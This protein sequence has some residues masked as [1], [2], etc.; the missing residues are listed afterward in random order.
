MKL[1]LW[2]LLD[3]LADMRPTGDIKD[4]APTIEAF[5][6]FAKG[7]PRSDAYVY[8]GS[9]AD[10]FGAEADSV[11]LVHRD[12]T[13]VIEHRAV[14]EV[15][16]RV[17]ETFDTYRLWDQRLQEARHAPQPY[18]AVLDV[19]HQMFHC[20]MFF[21]NKNL[22][23]YAITQQ[24]GKDEVYEE[25]DDV[26][27]L[28]T[29]PFTFLERWK[30]IAFP[31]G[32]REDVDPAILPVWEGMKF[33]NQIRA[34]CYFD[35]KVWGHFYIYYREK[36]VSPAVLQLSRHVADIFG[37]ML[38]E[39][40]ESSNEKYAKFS[41][42][43]DLLDA[44]DVVKG[45]LQS[46]CWQL[47]WS[48]NDTLTLYKVSPSETDYDHLL[49]YWL[50]DSISETAAGAAVFPYQHAIVVIVRDTAGQPGI[51][52]DHI[53]RLISINDYRCG[54]SFTFQGL[55]NIDSFYRQAGY[56]IEFARDAG[57]KT[58]Y[59]EDCAL[60]GLAREIKCRLQ[61]QDWIP[62]CLYRLLETDAT[63]GTEYYV[64][65][66]HLL[67]NKWHLGNTAKSLFIHRNTLLYRLEKI[68]NL[69][70]LDI[71]EESVCTFLRLCYEWLMQSHPVNVQP[72]SK[73]GLRAD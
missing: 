25:W 66:Y 16:N 39:K 70:V 72:P 32:Y 9:V 33:E 1:S 6:L 55:Q 65:L 22:H 26:K 44:R 50:C 68:E 29:M 60:Q 36:C 3:A 28:R 10:F 18:Q 7:D 13:I 35:G 43:V 53:V 15:I 64:T 34:N 21:G 69:M 4:G 73:D 30:S 23:I 63:Q 2:M 62:P 57:H 59:Y 56:A 24:Y 19:A 5:R 47:G 48:E 67:A 11:C 8:I 61:W 51:V 42:L 12:D 41:W 31:M 40:Q 46:L 45:A 54:V 20:P 14:A 58:H 27:R 37:T 17:I 38:R 49:F 52:L 71:H